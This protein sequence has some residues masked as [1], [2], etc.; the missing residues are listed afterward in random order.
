[1]CKRLKISI[2]ARFRDIANP[3]VTPIYR[4]NQL[5]MIKLFCHLELIII[6]RQEILEDIR[7]FTSQPVSRFYDQLFMNLDLSFIP[8]YPKTGRKGFPTHAMICAF[9]VMKT[10]GFPMITELV[11]YLSNNLLI[12]HYCGFNITKELP[13]YWTFDCFI[14]NIKHEWLSMLMQS[15][16]LIL[17][18]KG[19]DT[20]EIYN[21]IT[22][23]YSGECFIPLNKRGAKK[24]K[25][26]PK[27]NPICEAH[28]AMH[29]DGQFSDRGRTRS[30][31][32]PFKR[33]TTGSCPYNHKNFLNGKKI[34][35]VQSIK[36]FPMI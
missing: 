34:M 30:E 12:A 23:L 9:I 16:V 6:Q 15:Q 3:F 5:Q 31:N 28:L 27:G 21:Q 29:R 33:S 10:E 18:D 1:M 7:F 25:T 19:Y 32:C 20:K 26:L 24:L 22:Q 13:Y 14:K 17:A 8:E 35:A 2:H 4:N 11:D 36:Q